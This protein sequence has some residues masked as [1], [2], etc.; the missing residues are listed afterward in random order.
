MEKK[1]FL[2]EM[3]SSGGSVSVKRVLTFVAIC[4]LAICVLTELF[5]PL[6]VSSD[7]FSSLVTLSVSG[8][9][10]VASEKFTKNKPKT[11]ENEGIN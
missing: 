10:T 1:S 11:I 3:L 4:L 9:V 2:K 6:Q 7:T 8:L 5:T